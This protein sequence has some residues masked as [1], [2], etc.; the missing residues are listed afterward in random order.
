[1]ICKRCDRS[2]ILIV[3]GVATLCPDCRGS[4]VVPPREED[5]QHTADLAAI[6]INIDEEYAPLPAVRCDHKGGKEYWCDECKPVLPAC[7]E[8][9][10]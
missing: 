4:G 6:E 9:E 1:M 3:E 2:G 5:V 10:G 8:E 7:V